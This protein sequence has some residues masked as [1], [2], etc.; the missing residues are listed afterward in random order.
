M[1]PSL[2][3]TGDPEADA[4]LSNDPFA[5]LTGMMLDQQYPMDHA[6]QGPWKIAERMG[7]FDV[8]RIAEA[9]PDEFV[10]L[11]TTPPAIHRYSRTMAAR[12]QALAAVIVGEYDGDAARIWTAGPDGAEAQAD[13]KGPRE[14]SGDCADAA[15]VLA[16]L[17]AL[18]GFG[19]QKAR[20]FLALLGKQ[21]GVAPTGWREAAGAYGEAGSR[22]SIADV[23]DAQALAEVRA[24]KK[25]ARAAAQVAK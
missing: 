19:D 2:W 3:L 22:R 8:H 6:F 9:D 23:T 1:T 11:A 24:T 17:R 7:G 14:S 18:P 25:A 5:L 16:R 12:V 21:Y 13:A 15:L 20:I 4:L 10:A